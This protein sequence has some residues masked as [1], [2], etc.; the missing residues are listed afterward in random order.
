[1]T[2]STT[3]NLND[4]YPRPDATA[5]YPSHLF[6]SQTFKMRDGWILGPNDE[7]LLWVPSSN[8]TGLVHPPWYCWQIGAHITELDFRNFKCGTE[9][10]QC[11]EPMQ[12]K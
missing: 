1:M 2:G 12:T 4:I 6:P 9:W 11:H 8:R 3:A 5:Q 7:L 10:A